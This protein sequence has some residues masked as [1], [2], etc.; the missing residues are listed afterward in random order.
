M[1]R[2]T[3]TI[4]CF[5]WLCPWK[6][7]QQ[8][9]TA[10]LTPSGGTCKDSHLAFYYWYRPLSSTVRLLDAY[11]I[12]CFRHLWFL[13]LAGE[14]GPWV[15]VVMQAKGRCHGALSAGRECML[16]TYIQTERPRLMNEWMLWV[17]GSYIYAW[18]YDMVLI[19][20]TCSCIA[21]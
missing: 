13:I 1:Q 6:S 11:M 5:M 3:S 15:C 20:Q 18:Q 7:G 17:S 14:K 16:P 19:S 21:C 9:L 10:Q 8:L 12:F 2:L 4:L